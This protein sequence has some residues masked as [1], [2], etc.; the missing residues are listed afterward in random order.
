[1]IFRRI[2]QAGESAECE[3]FISIVRDALALLFVQMAYEH[4]NRNFTHLV[5]GCMGALSGQVSDNP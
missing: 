2:I 1:M 4:P 5:A 3:M